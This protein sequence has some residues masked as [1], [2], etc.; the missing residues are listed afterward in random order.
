MTTPSTTTTAAAL[1]AAFCVGPIAGCDVAPEAAVADG[2]GEIDFRYCPTCIGNAPKVNGSR[3]RELSLAG[4]PNIDGVKVLAAKDLY[5]GSLTL[6]VDTVTSSLKASN[7]NYQLVGQDLEGVDIELSTL[8]GIVKVTIVDVD[9]LPTWS[10]LGHDEYIYRMSYYDSNN[11]PQHLC[12]SSDPDGDWLTVLPHEIVVPGKTH[13]ITEDTDWF[14]L[15]CVGEAAFKMKML[16]YSRYSPSAPTKDER[17][18][19]IRMVTADYCGTGTSFTTAGVPVAWSDRSGTVSPPFA[20]VSM[21]AQWDEGGAV[22]LNTPRQFPIESIEDE[23]GAIPKCT[24][25][26]V[27]D[28]TWRTM[29]PW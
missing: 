29:L 11:A 25:N 15:A 2:A 4:A 5:Y 3:V 20:E 28:T 8:A 12:D 24:T 9:T 7:Q 17:V 21:E 13:V 14:T 27:T 1:F 22:C 10:D 19:T 23:C 26:W 18:A 6:G 16:G